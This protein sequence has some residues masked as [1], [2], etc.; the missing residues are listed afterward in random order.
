[1]KAHIVNGPIK[2][3]T[4]KEME[5][6]IKKNQISKSSWTL[7][8][9]GEMTFASAEERICL[10]GELCLLVFDGKGMLEIGKLMYWC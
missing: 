9:C 5:K 7:E 6:A 1:M 10:M 3:I 2:M 4:W 8:V